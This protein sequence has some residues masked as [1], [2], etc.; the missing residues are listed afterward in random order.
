MISEALI[1]NNT[2][3]SLSLMSD[4]KKKGIRNR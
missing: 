2:L 1:I 4:G 3:T